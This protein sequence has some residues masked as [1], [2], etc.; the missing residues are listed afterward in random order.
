M[1]HLVWFRSD[2]R[3]ADNPALH[4]ACAAP[5]DEVVAVFTV[6]P[7]QWGGHDWSP[8]KVGFLLRTLDALRSSLAALRIPL[9]IVTVAEFSGVPDALRTHARALG[10]ESIWFNDELEVNESRRDD[11]LERAFRADGRA[12]HRE[13]D[14]TVI[15]PGL[16][17]T[18]SGTPYTVFTP[19]KKAWWRIATV[20]GCV[21]LRAPRRRASMVC[22]ADPVP[23]S[24]PG[25]D[26]AADQ[27]DRWPAGEASALARLEAF[28]ASRIGRYH[29]ARDL[30][31][32]TGTSRLGPDLALGSIS[33]RTC[34]S[35]VLAAEP[36]ASEP[37]GGPEGPSV[38]L[39][40]I[41]WRE[42]YR[43]VLVAHP[44]VCMHRPF[45]RDTD[46]VVWRDDDAGFEAWASGRTGIP[47]VDAGMRQLLEEGWMHNRLRMIC[48]MFLTKNLLIDW[49]RGERHFMRHLVDGDLASNN[50]GWQWSA[51]T[52]TD[53]APYFRVFNPVSQSQKFD[54]D[55]D[56]IR[57]YVSE[58]S[59]ITG[60]AIHDPPALE[61]EACGY[62]QAICDLKATRQR[63]IDAFR[64]ARSS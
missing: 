35:R 37:D 16:I 1:R 22:E 29:D 55:G 62:P 14:Q 61:R 11:A 42:F 64:A 27:P 25:F 18:G 31:A 8:I 9:T 57:R 15:E 36:G 53:A 10:C 12:V 56:T 21:P 43:G 40:E 38:W 13:H 20:D 23:E 41:I 45:K 19:F 46:A 32:V 7:A 5:G 59:G 34:V 58:L 3:V 28:I 52:G 54:A 4:G 63:A 49:R 17:R 39:S 51:S 30:P 6:C 2:L 33:A 50:G 48:A 44:R 24:V 60:K 47:I 26:P